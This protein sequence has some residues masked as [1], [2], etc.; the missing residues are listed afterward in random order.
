MLKP[1]SECRH[2][3]DS[4][5]YKEALV[6]LE[7][8]Q[9]AT[10]ETL[11]L[12]GRALSGLGQFA[13][14]KHCFEASL[15]DNPHDHEALAGLG[16]LAWIGGNHPEAIKNLNAAIQLAPQNPRYR[17]QRGLVYLQLKD[18]A[19]ALIDLDAAQELGGTDPAPVLAKAQLMLIQGNLDATQEA[20]DKARRLGAEEGSLA[21]LE[22]A[23]ARVRGD[24]PT[25]LAC[26]RRALAADPTRVGLW[27]ETLGLVSQVDRDHLDEE[28]QHAL[29]HHPKDEHILILTAARW[30]EKGQLD[31][32]LTLLQ[33]AV[34]AQP[35]SQSLL[36]FLG[37]YLRE[38]QRNEESLAC[39]QRALELEPKSAKAYFGY[40]LSCANRDDAMQAFQKA[41]ELDPD[42]VVFQYHYGA[43]LSAIGCYAE[44]LVP[45]SRAITLDPH[46]WRAYHERS[47][48]FE[49]L[50]RF[51][52][53]Q[54]DRVHYQQA[55]TQA[56]LSPDPLEAYS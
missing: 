31:Q 20:M 47:I 29:A 9:P 56:G 41:I 35:E 52:S 49:N 11:T 55:R 50:G 42:N 51:A 14:A 12:R 3:L 13:E 30:R 17:G 19:A 25:A 16:L 18:A 6:A 1:T 39:F 54:D 45:L 48:C 2:L 27:W 10:S 53:A 28:L 26:Y 40:A 44:A 22:G 15:K 7:N 33:E 37:G 8:T 43:V 21:S 32:A 5:R 23:L 38:A 36:Q 34:V 46:F 24:L 4:E